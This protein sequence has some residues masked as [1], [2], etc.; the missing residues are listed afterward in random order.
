[1]RILIV[2]VAGLAT[3]FSQSVG[4]DCLKCIY[5]PNNICE[6][7]LYRILHQPVRFDKYIVVG[8]YRFEELRKTI[9]EQFDDL[10][11]RIILVNNSHFAEYG[12][13]YSLFC[14]LRTAAQF[15]FSQ[16][17]FAEGDL[18]IDT[19]TF[20]KI[21]NSPQNVITSN[22][23]PIL[24]NKSVVFYYN[25]QNRIHYLYD[26]GH[27]LLTVK[28]PFRAIYNSGQ[29]W[30]FSDSVKLRQL[31]CQTHRDDWKGTNLIPIEKYFSQLEKDEYELIQFKKWINCNTIS[32][33]QVV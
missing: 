31:L 24:S 28:E 3:R 15:N 32:D 12:S 18:I 27:N 6:S 4:Y 2:T 8:G 29:V 16:I 33:F 11:K 9:E 7:I 14:G 20:I 1:M 17:V 13:G 10:A 5:Y 21:C 26:T 19:E 30:K 22:Q 23:D 25:E